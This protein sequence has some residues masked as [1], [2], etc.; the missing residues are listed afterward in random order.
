LISV[1][2]PYLFNNG[3]HSYLAGT[4]DQRLAG[5]QQMLDDPTI[6]A[7]ICA[8]GGYGTTR[9]VDRIDL[10]ALKKNPKWIIGFSD[11]TALHLQL[12][13]EEIQSIHGIMPVLFDREESMPSL[14]SLQSILFGE[15]FE[16]KANHDISNKPGKAAGQLIGG[17]LSL[18]VDSIGTLHEVE[19]NGKILIVEEID[20]YLYK[21]DRMIV[22]LKRAG[23][24][25][26]L[27]G[28]VVGYF[29]D[30]KDSDLPFGEDYKDIIRF[31]TREYGFPIGFNFQT[32]HENPNFAW[33]QGAIASLQVADDGSKLSVV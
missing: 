23:K 21:I 26:K 31:H 19:T 3:E 10:T 8:R 15:K 18:I 9:I 20:E 29:T 16:L 24:L 30:I 4:D 28:L 1:L 12:A 22:Q 7:V 33:V 11:V 17:N 5:I 13:F 32:G 27:A 25:E 14:K 2:S 6:R